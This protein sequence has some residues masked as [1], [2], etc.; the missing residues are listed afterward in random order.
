MERHFPG[1]H[2]IVQKTKAIL[3]H[4]H[5]QPREVREGA[6]VTAQKA[7][8]NLR[9]DLI[10]GDVKNKKKL[11]STDLRAIVDGM[12]TGHPSTHGI[13]RS[14]LKQAVKQPNSQ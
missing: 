9:A 6:I 3:N 1:L 8:E 13:Q 7:K 2:Y 4:P 11:T 5:T 14:A 12:S 10:K